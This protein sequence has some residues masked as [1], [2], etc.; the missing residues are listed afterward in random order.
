VKD[1]DKDSIP[2]EKD[3][4]PNEANTRQS[5]TDNDGVGDACDADPLNPSGT[6]DTS[7][8]S[9]PAWIKNN[10]KWWAEGQIGDDAFAQGIEFLI[11]EGIMV[12]PPT[13]QGTSSGDEQIPSWVKNNAKWWSEGQIDDET[14]V[15]GIQFLIEEGIIRV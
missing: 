4:C 15:Q 9:I 3:N 14:F 11:Q 8:V 7:V 5:D 2:D 6:T 1:S 10:A 13:V 12:V